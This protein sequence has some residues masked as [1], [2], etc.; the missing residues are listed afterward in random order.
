MEVRRATLTDVN[1]VAALA[2]QVWLDTY[3][4]LGVRSTMSDYV[5]SELSPE[6]FQ[7]FVHSPTHALLVAAEKAHIVGLAVVSRNSTCPVDTTPRPELDKLYVQPALQRRGVGRQ[8]LRAA[9]AEC[10]T[11]SLPALWLAV[12]EH[13]QRAID[14]YEGCGYAAI[15]A[16]EIHLG[17]EKHRNLVYQKSLAS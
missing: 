11:W 6:R 7:F 1:N 16:A 8:L 4:P 10:V 15:G 5:F 14:F 13:N 12:W 9:E 3:A 17:P 2:I